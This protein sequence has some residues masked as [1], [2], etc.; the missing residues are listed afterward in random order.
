MHSWM[1]AHPSCGRSFPKA[2]QHCG[3]PSKAALSVN[4]PGMAVEAQKRPKQEEKRKSG[5]HQEEESI[6]KES[7]LT[8][9]SEISIASTKQQDATSKNFSHRKSD[10]KIFLNKNR[11]KTI[12]AIDRER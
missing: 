10:L 1:I 4:A 8:I 6:G 7:C 12:E 11:R 2:T 9:P 3:E 5:G